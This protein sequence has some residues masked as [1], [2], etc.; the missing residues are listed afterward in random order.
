MRISLRQPGELGRIHACIHAGEDRETA[1]RRKRKLTLITEGS[2]VAP[3]RF[4]NLIEN[5]AHGRCSS[6]SK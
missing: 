4:Q 5:T 3:I 6:V 2:A 1:R